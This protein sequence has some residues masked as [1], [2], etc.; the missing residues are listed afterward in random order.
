MT[1][2]DKN[3]ISLQ[4]YLLKRYISRWIIA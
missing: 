2:I 3:A 4:T 1:E